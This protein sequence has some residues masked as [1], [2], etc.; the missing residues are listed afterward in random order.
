MEVKEY[1]RYKE[2]LEALKA[3]Q[4]KID[5]GIEA[6]M[7]QLKAQ[8][9]DSIEDAK[10]KLEELRKQMDETEKRYY[11]SLEELKGLYTWQFL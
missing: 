9:I 11:E 10:I 3:K 4:A 1:E 2:K 5:G 7:K 8:G 6:I